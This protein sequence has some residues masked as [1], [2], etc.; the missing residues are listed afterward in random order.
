LVI[1]SLNFQNQGSAVCQPNQII[2]PEFVN[3]PFEGVRNLK[4]YVVVLDPSTH[5]LI[6]VQLKRFVCFPAAVVNAHI[7]VRALGVL[8]CLSAVP[9]KHVAGGA[10]GSL[11]V[12]HRFES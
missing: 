12:E 6:A 7:D 11:C 9:G 1:L 4:T 10:D 5:I 3:Y 2:W 8:A